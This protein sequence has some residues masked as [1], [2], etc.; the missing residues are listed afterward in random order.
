MSGCGSASCA[1]AAAASPG[2]SGRGLRPGPGRR[3][4]CR[5]PLPPPTRPGAGGRHAEAQLLK[6]LPEVL[7]GLLDRFC[8]TSCSG[9]SSMR[10]LMKSGRFNR[11][12]DHCE[13]R[14]PSAPRAARQSP[15]QPGS[16]DP[17]A[18]S[19]AYP[20]AVAM[21]ELGRLRVAQKREDGSSRGRCW[22][23]W[24]STFTPWATAN[25]A[26]VG[27]LWLRAGLLGA[28]RRRAGS[29]PRRRGGLI[30]AYRLLGDV[31]QVVVPLCDLLADPALAEQLARVP[32]VLRR[33]ASCDVPARR[34]RRS[35]AGILLEAEIW[36]L[37]ATGPAHR[38]R[39]R[40]ARQLL[41][42][43]SDV[44]RA[45]NWSRATSWRCCRCARRRFRPKRR[46]IGTAA[47]RRPGIG[48]AG[49]GVC[50]V[51]AAARRSSATM[52]RGRVLSEAAQLLLR[53]GD[54]DGAAAGIADRLD[55]RLL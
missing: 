3:C 42:Q 45:W 55:S 30:S 54:N 52:R 29:K 53:V 15:Q 33:C 32:E 27:E 11:S 1:R 23:P 44:L 5:A 6:A 34:S 22:R 14:A 26:A 19:A 7:D 9:A 38:D 49:A 8:P 17:Q 24:R 51:H 35:A 25:W 37:Q 48:G 13:Q 12:D 20:E 47:H 21:L 40:N 41:P 31:P 39:R 50:P 10:C 16:G 2:R 46:W 28:K 43:S 18:Q 4:W 36:L